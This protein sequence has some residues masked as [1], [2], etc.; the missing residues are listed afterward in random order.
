M[1]VVV[2]CR[3]S[4]E[5]CQRKAHRDR[6]NTHEQVC[7]HQVVHCPGRHRHSQILGGLCQWSGCLL[8]LPMHLGRQTTCIQKLNCTT[9][10]GKCTATSWIGDYNSQQLPGHSVFNLRRE[11]GWKP[12]LLASRN[13]VQYLIYMTIQRKHTGLWFI[14][15]RSYR[16]ED[17]LKRIKV[18]LE[19]RKKG[20]A[21]SVSLITP[22]QKY[23]YEGGVV[24]HSMTNAEAMQ[25]GRILLLN[26][27]QVELL[28]T[29]DTIFEY[30]ITVTIMPGG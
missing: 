19:V 6:I 13:I 27:G 4:E 16:E 21:N 12:I 8:R 3:W 10:D 14:M 5:G 29:R 11:I 18:K 26:D 22:Q 30:H 15:I 2:K 24:S 20:D 1:K 17:V 9:E 23:T 25:S 28:K 7:H